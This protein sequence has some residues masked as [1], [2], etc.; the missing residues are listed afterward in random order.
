MAV[1]VCHPR[2]YQAGIAACG[3]K[4]DG[5]ADLALVL[6]E[7]PASA[8][9]VFTLNSVVAAPVIVSRTQIRSGSARA[10]V[11][12]SGLANACT[13]EGGLADAWEMVDTAAMA[14]EVPR[15]QVLVASTGVIGPRL[16]MPSVTAAIGAR[17][18]CARR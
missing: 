7:S 8:A 11:T 18:N 10:I 17:R 15:E 2:G 1:G 9:G 14:L 16:P 6:S 3:M 12:N 4:A 5:A 13:G